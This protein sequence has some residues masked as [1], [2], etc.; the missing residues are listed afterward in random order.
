[1]RSWDDGEWRVEDGEWRVEG[2]GEVKRVSTL[3]PPS[4][5]LR[6]CYYFLG[7]PGAELRTLT[8]AACSVAPMS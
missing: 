3:R 7:V 4:S 6:A 2:G 5:I 8:S 1:M